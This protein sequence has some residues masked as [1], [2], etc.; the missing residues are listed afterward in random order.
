MRKLMI[1]TLAL[2]SVAGLS[3][4]SDKTQDSAATTAESAGD[5][6][7]GAAASAGDAVE[8]GAD[9]VGEAAKDGA[10]AVGDTAEDAAT[11]TEAERAKAEADVQDESVEKAKAD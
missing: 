3:A 4:C 11:T 6:V 10:Q 5:D 2:A 1:A 9:S 8:A 7:E